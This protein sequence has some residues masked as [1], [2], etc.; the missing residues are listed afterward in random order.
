MNP[1]SNGMARGMREVIKQKVWSALC[2]EESVSADNKKMFDDTEYEAQ[3][4]AHPSIQPADVR[5]Q[6]YQVKSFGKKFQQ[7]VQ[8]VKQRDAQLM[9]YKKADTATKKGLLTA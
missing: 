9:E 4:T 3:R 8:S 1:M 2:N 6:N 7:A 5:I